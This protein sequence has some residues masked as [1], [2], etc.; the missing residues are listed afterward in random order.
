VKPAHEAFEAGRFE[1]IAYFEPLYLKDFVVTASK[2]KI[3]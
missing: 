3:F 1:D 2:K